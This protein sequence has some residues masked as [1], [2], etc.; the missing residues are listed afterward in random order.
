[1]FIICILIQN[2]IGLAQ[3]LKDLDFAIQLNEIQ[4]DKKTNYS[5]YTQHNQ[6]EIQLIFAGLFLFY[7][8]CISSQDGNVCSFTPSCS[9]YALL[10]IK[11]KG[12][13]MGSIQFFDRFSRC[14][15]L[16][17]QNYT[18]H[19]KTHLLYDPID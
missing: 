19:S 9:E 3:N 12:L 15:G 18:R 11:K 7:K 17:P 14:H 6:T 1:M 10:G 4:E 13:I 5:K 16:S 2:N 8:E